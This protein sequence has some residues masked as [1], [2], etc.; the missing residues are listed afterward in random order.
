MYG[1]P[2]KIK[3]KMHCIDTYFN[4]QPPV[5]LFNSWFTLTFKSAD[6]I[7][8]NFLER[9]WILSEKKIFITNSPFST[10]SQFVLFFL[11]FCFFLSLS[12]LM[13]PLKSNSSYFLLNKNINFSKN[14]GE[15]KMENS[16]Q[17][18]GEVMNLVLQ[19]I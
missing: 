8:Q 3:E 11:F 6:I 17:T 13:L 15:S 14:K 9:Y 1:I 5:I 10:N 12:F 4:L 19:L 18:F 16:T 2:T 7:S